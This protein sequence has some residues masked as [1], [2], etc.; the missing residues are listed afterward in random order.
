MPTTAQG[1]KLPKALSAG[2][3]TFWLHCRAHGLTPEREHFFHPTRKFRF[4]FA[5]PSER[6][7]VEVEGVSHEGGRHQRIAGFAGD[8]VK[9]NSAVLL[10]WRVLRYTTQMVLAGTAIDDVL[11]I[12]AS[13]TKPCDSGRGAA[14]PKHTGRNT[15]G[16]K[17]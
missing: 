6:I 16:E 7:G 12:L 17:P 9:Y 3:E 5:F 13:G 2:E 4:D 8:C 11:A 14:E 15:H 1:I 10:G